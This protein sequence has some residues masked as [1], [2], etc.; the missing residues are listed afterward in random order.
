MKEILITW[1]SKYGGTEGIARMIGE[2]L[3]ARGKSVVTL[4]PATDV[5]DLHRFDAVIIGGGLYGNRWQKDARRFV[6]RH[7]RELRRVPVWMFSSGPLDDSAEKADLPPSHQVADLMD[8]I[9]ALGH[10]TFGGRLAPD[11][12]GFPAAAMAKTT[13]G[14]WRNPEQI[15]GWA[16]QLARELHW[17]RPGIPVVRPGRA[18]HRLAAHAVTGAA[19]CALLLGGLLQTVDA[20]TALLLHGLAAPALFAAIAVH[21]FRARGARAPLPTA[22]TFAAATAALEL[23]A[24]SGSLGAAALADRIA[25][26]W[27]PLL[28]IFSISWT[29]GGLFTTLPWPKPPRPATPRPAAPRPA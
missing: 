13:S 28:L 1:G 27:L 15:R 20:W 16:G 10:R 23:V 14:D 3:E 18:L 11:V 9:G 26:W 24:A 8:R 25:G 29:I 2:S 5:Y 7:V 21:Y 4:M 12:R 17:A 6:T 22:I 19:L